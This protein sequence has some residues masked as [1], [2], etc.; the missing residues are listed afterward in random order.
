[1]T[2]F[3]MVRRIICYS[4]VNHFCNGNAWECHWKISRVV[5]QNSVRI[6][7]ICANVV[8]DAVDAPIQQRNYVNIHMAVGFSCALMMIAAK[9]CTN[10]AQQCARLVVNAEDAL[11]QLLHFVV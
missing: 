7:K 3:I 6:V 10:S 8:G 2:I 4:G 1:M 11:V 9:Y 5:Q